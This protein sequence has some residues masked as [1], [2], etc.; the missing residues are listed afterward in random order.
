MDDF[1]DI[2]LDQMNG[3]ENY[4]I[5]RI[6]IDK[7]FCENNFCLS[8]CCEDNLN[9][10]LNQCK[11]LQFYNKNSAIKLNKQGKNLENKN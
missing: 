5:I 1:Q 11:E 6:C 8:K 2:C 7:S 10:T 9:S 4:Y 3:T